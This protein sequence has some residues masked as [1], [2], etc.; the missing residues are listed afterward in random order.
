MIA[1][2][3]A[4]A[5]MLAGIGGAL[6]APVYFVQPEMGSM[7]S[8]KAF[9]ASIVGGSAVYRARSSVVFSWAS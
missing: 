5:C 6:L 8:L 3:F 4:G 9:A 1:A 2:T 7:F